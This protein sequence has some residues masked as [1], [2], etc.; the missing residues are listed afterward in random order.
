MS[1]LGKNSLLIKLN[2]DSFWHSG[3]EIDDDIHPEAEVRSLSVRR[4]LN[5][6]NNWLFFFNSNS[7]L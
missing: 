7:L 2:E 3:V 1:T 6:K 5:S 4:K